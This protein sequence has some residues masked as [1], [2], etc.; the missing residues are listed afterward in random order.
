MRRL[1]R[2]AA[3]INQCSYFTR[4]RAN[5]YQSVISY[6]TPKPHTGPWPRASRYASKHLIANIDLGGPDG[7]GTA[8]RYC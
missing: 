3:L 8:A 7:L 5:F 1:L 4:R 2:G 6:P